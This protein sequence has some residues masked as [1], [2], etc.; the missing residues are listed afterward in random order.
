MQPKRR[1]DQRG[2]P[3]FL[4]AICPFVRRDKQSRFPF[5]MDMELF[6]CAIKLERKPE[7]ERVC[8]IDL[9]VGNRALLPSDVEQILEIDVCAKHADPG[10]MPID[11]DRDCKTEGIGGFGFV[12]V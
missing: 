11:R 2:K 3:W 5:E 6:P 12:D 8:L 10:G 7:Y 9:A 1:V 4:S